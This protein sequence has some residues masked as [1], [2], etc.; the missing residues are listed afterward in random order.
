MSVLLD[1]AST[2]YLEI[3]V[4]PVTTFPCTMAI[5]F[6][7]ND[8]TIEQN[9]IVIAD[10]DVEKHW[11]V[12][13]I[14]GDI[15]GNPVRARTRS[16]S[17]SDSAATST[18]YAAN[19]WHHALGT[20]AS[21]TDRKAYIDGGS[22]G[23]NTGSSDPAGLDRL[24]IGRVGDSTPT[25]YFSGLLAEAAIW[26]VI[27]TAAEITILP[28]GF[29]PKVIRPQSLV[30]Y[31]SLIDL[32]NLV[33]E[34]GGLVLTAF[35]TPVAGSHVPKVIY[36]ALPQIITAPSAAAAAVTGILRHPMDIYKHA[37]TR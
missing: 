10:K 15:E 32:N 3:D 21:S 24:S 11:I 22:E 28:L 33:D 35:N 25:D 34:V 19:T 5:W 16:G 8:D 18:G 6:N 31:D 4:A 12:L 17:G 27:L 7:S 30:Y 14:K 1:D 26:N 2:E 20:F 23:T 13:G 36:P 37:L 9:L 29:S